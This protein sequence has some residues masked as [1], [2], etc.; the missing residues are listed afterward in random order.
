MI[1]PDLL[2]AFSAAPDSEASPAPAAEHL[3][4]PFRPAPPPAESEPEPET[5]EES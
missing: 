1:R 5:T 3:A 2:P 4:L